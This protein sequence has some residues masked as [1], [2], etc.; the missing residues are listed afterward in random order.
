MSQAQPEKNQG[1]AIRLALDKAA[2]KA[3]GLTQKQ[4]AAWRD[5]ISR[6]PTVTGKEPEGRKKITMWENITTYGGW[7]AA[8]ILGA[9]ALK[10]T[11]RIDIDEWMKR[12]DEKLKERIQRTCT[13]TS[14]VVRKDGTVV[15]ESRYV[16]PSGTLSYYCRRCSRVVPTDV[17]IMEEAEYWGNHPK[18][19]TKREAE[20]Q[21][22][23]KKL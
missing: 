1:A 17:G 18:E 8:A 22:L 4:V 5:A 15:V 9:F 6:E 14:L 2:G 13:H 7:I 11:V 16:S 21:K 19:W 10:A 12:R 20:V 3:A 23:A